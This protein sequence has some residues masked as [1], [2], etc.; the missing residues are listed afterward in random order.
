L[1]EYLQIPVEDLRRAAE[2]LLEHVRSAHG[3]MIE[4][5]HD[6][7]WAIPPDALYD[8]YEKPAELTIGQLTES[9]DNVSGMVREE[10][11]PLSYGLVWLSDVLRAIGYAKVS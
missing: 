1:T 2:L 10:Q 7:F 11:P 4:I 6:M 8:V 5:E 9:W 3:E